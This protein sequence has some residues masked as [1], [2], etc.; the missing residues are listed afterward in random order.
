MKVLLAP[1]TRNW[2]D[3][4]DEE[5][6]AIDM[7]TAKAQPFSYA[8]AVKPIRDRAEVRK[9]VPEPVAA[10]LTPAEAAA[11]ATK[12]KGKG[13]EVVKPVAAATQIG[14]SVKALEQT[15]CAPKEPTVQ[16]NMSSTGPKPNAWV[17]GAWRRPEQVRDDAL[18]TIAEAQKQALDFNSP[19]EA[20][21]ASQKSKPNK[22]PR[23]F[24]VSEQT[25]PEPQVIEPVTIPAPTPVLVDSIRPT[26]PNPW[27]NGPKKQGKA[28]PVNEVAGATAE[29]PK[30]LKAPEARS[31]QVA[32]SQKSD[33][34]SWRQPAGWSKPNSASV[35]AADPTDS[36]PP[37]PKNKK[38]WSKKQ[39]KAKAEANTTKSQ[40]TPA[41]EQPVLKDA[42]IEP[43]VFSKAVSVTAISKPVTA[44]ILQAEMM[45]P[46]SPPVQTAKE[47]VVVRLPPS[48][49][50][51]VT[52]ATPEN[53]SAVATRRKAVSSVVPVIPR[54]FDC[55]KART[56]PQS[57]PQPKSLETSTG[58]EEGSTI[59]VADSAC[60]PYRSRASSIIT[61]DTVIITD[62]SQSLPRR[63]TFMRGDSEIQDHEQWACPL[64]GPYISP[65]C[66]EN[67]ESNN[68]IPSNLSPTAK[69]FVPRRQTE[70]HV[71]TLDTSAR[72]SHGNGRT[73]PDPS[74]SLLQLSP[75][76]IEVVHPNRPALNLTI[77]P[78]EPF[79]PHSQQYFAPTEIYQPHPLP[80]RPKQYLSPPMTRAPALPTRAPTP[81]P[82]ILDSLIHE[83]NRLDIILMQDDLVRE[84]EARVARLALRGLYPDGTKR[85]TLQV[86]A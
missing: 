25:T 2:A 81:T 41:A 11:C 44:E 15:I 6:E 12:S 40:T 22:R 42:P 68:S 1:C 82:E 52:P 4:E 72:C 20:Q 38:R 39:R 24:P 77:P 67:P 29:V 75:N 8:D 48:P 17:S 46:L 51:P 62:S 27:T 3:E 34:E 74:S 63:P 76:G 66:M 7:V 56:S 45:T 55:S 37:A 71:H 78:Q 9:P 84:A 23:R 58:T 18:K 86:E 31:M 32:R 33:R 28:A 30:P 57:E 47:E 49:P 73:L 16:V 10:E 79:P 80:P 13:K 43:S 14:E 35:S 53:K 50:Q 5:V 54:S 83:C 64:N 36:A 59:I 61:E 26:K 19:V 85:D 21:V 70:Q 65:R 60:S 69:P